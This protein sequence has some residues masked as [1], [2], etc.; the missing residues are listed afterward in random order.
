MPMCVLVWR[1]TDGSA[2]VFSF[3]CDR[4]ESVMS[5]SGLKW[6][7]QITFAALSVYV[8]TSSNNHTSFSSLSLTGHSIFLVSSHVAQE[9]VHIVGF[10]K[11]PG[12][13]YISSYYVWATALRHSGSISQLEKCI[14]FSKFGHRDP[15]NTGVIVR[16]NSL[17]YLSVV[18]KEVWKVVTVLMM[19][20]KYY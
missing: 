16:A 20:W 4:G 15:I 5:S 11:W 19:D 9:Q 1:K 14:Y 7:L 3:L 18:E 13:V 10:S 17:L 12:N 6:S 2:P 8:Q